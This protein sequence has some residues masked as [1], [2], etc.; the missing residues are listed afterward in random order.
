MSGTTSS[1]GPITKMSTNQ[2]RL[3]KMLHP[4]VRGEAKRSITS[5]LHILYFVRED[6]VAQKHRTRICRTFNPTRLLLMHCHVVQGLLLL[7]RLLTTTA[8]SNQ[9]E[10]ILKVEESDTERFRGSKHSD[11]SLRVA[12]K[13]FIPPSYCPTWS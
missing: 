10:S 11:L 12:S 9:L 3:R 13:G 2:K 5:T 1:H 8:G 6:P 7:E 4:W